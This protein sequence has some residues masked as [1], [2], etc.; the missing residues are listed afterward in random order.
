MLM[1]T[2]AKLDVNWCMT[3]GLAANGTGAVEIGKLAGEAAKSAGIET[4]VFDRSG[5]RFH[6]KV[7]ALAEA[8]REAGL[9]L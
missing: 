4:V 1:D 5:A 3:G 7:K 9:K 8:A 6:G 2:L